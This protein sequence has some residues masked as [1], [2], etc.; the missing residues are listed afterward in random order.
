MSGCERGVTVVVL[1]TLSFAA[2]AVA[3]A[4]LFPVPLPPRTNAVMAVA[5]G[6]G[7]GALWA[8]FES[9]HAC[10]GVASGAVCDVSAVASVLLQPDA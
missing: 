9:P 4:C 8:R 7:G 10:A 5:G 3:A 2:C 6:D 1:M